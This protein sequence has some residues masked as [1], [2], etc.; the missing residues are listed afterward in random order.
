MNKLYE[1]GLSD[2]ELK[3]LSYQEQCN[4]LNVNPVLVASHF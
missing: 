3:D 1:S 2:E 4:L